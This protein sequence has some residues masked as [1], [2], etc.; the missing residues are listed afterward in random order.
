MANSIPED[1]IFRCALYKDIERNVML[2]Q[3]CISNDVLIQAFSTQLKNEKNVILTDLYS[4][5]LAHLQLD[6]TSQPG[7]V[8]GD[9]SLRS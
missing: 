9:F 5:I 4:Q 8:N 2:K 1:F 3:C 7:E 6:K